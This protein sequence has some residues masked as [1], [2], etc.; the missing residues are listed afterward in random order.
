MRPRVLTRSGDELMAA[1]TVLII[2]GEPS[3]STAYFKFQLKRTN[4]RS[5]A[6]EAGVSYLAADYF[7]KPELFSDELTALFAPNSPIVQKIARAKECL[8]A[9]EQHSQRF[10]MFCRTR[11]I[12]PNEAAHEATL[13]HNRVFNPDVPADAQVLGFRPDW[14]NV[15]ADPMP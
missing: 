5:R 13:W 14:T 4:E 6:Y 11:R 10:T 1:M 3:Q 2:P 8:L 12:K 15:H 9:F 7:Q